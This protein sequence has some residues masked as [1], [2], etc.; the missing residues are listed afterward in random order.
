MGGWRE[1]VQMLKELAI[2]I[3]GDVLTVLGTFFLVW[4]PYVSNKRR[5]QLRFFGLDR[6]HQELVVYLSG[7]EV[8]P[9]GKAAPNFKR[10]QGFEGTLVGKIESDAANMISAFLTRGFL[11]YFAVELK[12]FMAD[13]APRFRNL[14]VSISISPDE[15]QFLAGTPLSRS[16]TICLAGCGKMMLQ[17]VDFHFLTQF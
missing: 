11:A 16:S 2:G 17:T 14:K 6:D 12:D 3:L 5:K 15:Y 7:V 4:M 10:L 1:G 13:A 8:N 9:A